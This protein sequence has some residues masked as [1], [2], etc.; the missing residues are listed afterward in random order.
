MSDI[1]R[2]GILTSG[3]DCA[4][5]NAV[6]RAVAHRAIEGYGWQVYG[7]HDGTLGLLRRPVDFEELTRERTFELGWGPLSLRLPPSEDPYTGI[8]GD[9][10]H[11]DLEALTEFSRESK[12]DGNLLWG[13][14][15]G[16]KYERR[17]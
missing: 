6:I 10:I 8:K 5:L 15:Q 11:E 7:I 13:R 2:I 17:A 12:R 1:K 9:A 14:I 4:G 16:T 3:G